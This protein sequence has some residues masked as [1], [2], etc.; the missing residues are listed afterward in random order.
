DFEFQSIGKGVAEQGTEEERQQEKAELAQKEQ[1]YHSLLG[2]MQAKLGDFVKEV[3][4]SNRL[5]S[6]PSCLVGNPSDLSPQMEQ[7]MKAMNQPTPQSKR[8]LELNPKHPLMEKLQEKFVAS[9]SD[10]AI[11]D[12]AYLLYG[13]ALLAEASPLPDPAKFSKLLSEL[14]VKAV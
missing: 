10:P 14:M 7:L 6:S 13:Q 9:Q 8:I 11:N 1:E 3:R 5:T 2:A 12:I 4:L